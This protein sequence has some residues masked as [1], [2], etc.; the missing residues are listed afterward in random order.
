MR[1]DSALCIHWA[2]DR[3]S[4]RGHKKA[5]SL[6]VDRL[7]T[8]LWKSRRWS[9]QWWIEHGASW[10]NSTEIYTLPSD[11]WSTHFKGFM[12]QCELRYPLNLKPLL[13]SI[14]KA[15]WPGPNMSTASHQLACCSECRFA[16]IFGDA[17]PSFRFIF[18]A[19]RFDSKQITC[20][21]SVSQFPPNVW[22]RLNDMRS[23]CAVRPFS[24][25]AAESY[26]NKYIHYTRSVAKRQN[27]G[28]EGKVAIPTHSRKW[29]WYFTTD[30]IRGAHGVERNWVSILQAPIDLDSV[31]RFV[32]KR[33]WNETRVSIVLHLH[34]I[35]TVFLWIGA[36]L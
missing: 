22:P 7:I 33:P 26:S 13:E 19:D 18:R 10:R 14:Q 16:F 24:P 29:K 2:C 30:C 1:P 34:P 21:V 15:S 12:S 17:R 6:P 28:V 32:K 20:H 35:W 27:H 31:D 3:V 4:G 8:P 36:E 5:W 25:R 9:S 23:K 11:D